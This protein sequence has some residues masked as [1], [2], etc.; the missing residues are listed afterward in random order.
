MTKPNGGLPTLAVSRAMLAAAPGRR[1][2]DVVYGASD[3]RTFARRLPAEDL[4]FAIKEIGLN[5][6]AELVGLAAPSQ[7]RT[8]VDLD[9]WE[10]SEPDPHRILLWLRLAWEGDPRT[11]RAKRAALDPEVVLVVLKTQT[12]VHPLEDGELQAALR[13]D[14]FIRTPDNKY[15]VEILA[16]GDD[17][18]MVRRVLEDFIDESPLEAIRL[19][20]AVRWEIRTELEE[21]ALRWR[22]GRLRDLGFPDLEEAIRIWAPLPA[23]W[24]PRE[25]RPPAGA[26]AGVPALLL[27]TSQAQLLLDRVAEHLPDEARPLFNEG[28]LYLLNCSLVADGVAPRDLDFAR[29]TLAATRSM[30]SLGLEEAAGGDEQEALRILSTTPASELFRLAVTRLKHLA[31]EAGKVLARTRIADGPSLLD[32][33]AAE[34]LAGVRRKRPRLYDPPK[35][36]EKPSSSELWRPFRSRAD[37]TAVRD[38]L[39]QAS[40]LADVLAVF[41][42]SDAS[43]EQLADA[44][45]R[46]A[47]AITIGQLVC[48]AAAR[49]LLGEQAS[50]DP[51]APDR[52]SDLCAAFS[53]G[54]LREEAR[55]RLE[56]FFA[57]LRGRIAPSDGEA[58]EAI[59][60]GW[61]S[62]LEGEIGSPCRSGALDPRFV[63]AVLFRVPPDAE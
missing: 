15:L 47:T 3:P 36:G 51:I 46:A 57:D 5:D 34:V 49:V 2:L 13:S 14:N 8:F 20:E 6:A 11:F 24:K 28:L 33:P 23:E 39:Q 32:S 25:G 18:A 56:G 27:A 40:V 63:E 44:C 29:S 21:T 58:F 4:F 61:V 60:R 37:L 7:F 1:K 55:Q 50:P 62:R 53:E 10:G 41:D 9:G 54:T 12:E 35:E 30:L 43:F 42:L 31:L 17:G 38:A 16:E 22:T 59:T 26:V 19:F 52:A 45:G 48:T